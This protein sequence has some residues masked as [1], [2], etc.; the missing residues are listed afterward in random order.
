M[1]LKRQLV[2]Q[3]AKRLLRPAGAGSPRLAAHDFPPCR[4]GGGHGD[5]GWCQG[6]VLVSL[7]HKRRGEECRQQRRWRRPSGGGGCRRPSK[8]ASTHHNAGRFWAARALSTVPLPPRRTFTRTVPNSCCWRSQALTRWRTSA[9]DDDDT[10]C[11]QPAQD[12]RV[13]KASRIACN[14][15]AGDSGLQYDDIAQLRAPS[16][17]KSR[18]FSRARMPCCVERWQP[19]THILKLDTSASKLEKG[20]R[21]QAPSPS[22]THHRQFVAPPRSQPPH[23]SP[24]LP[25]HAADP[26]GIA[27]AAHI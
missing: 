3:N 8:R 7:Q 12:Q 15:N 21:P 23:S 19:C 24:W 13:C 5:G 6:G 9:A 11:T 10:V 17:G 18:V 14:V 20:E 27:R 16:L 4:H 1:C 2:V 22:A 25:R 26:A